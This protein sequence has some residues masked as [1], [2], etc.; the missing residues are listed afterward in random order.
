LWEKRS[1]SGWQ[2]SGRKPEAIR[3]EA[4]AELNEGKWGPSRI[5]LAALGGYYL[6][7]T[8]TLRAARF[9]GTEE[10]KDGR[11]AQTV[12][13][14]IVSSAHGIHTLYQ[15]VIDGRAMRDEVRKVDEGGTV[16]TP[17]DG[18]SAA[19]DNQWVRQEFGLEEL[20]EPSLTAK[21]EEAWRQ[22]RTVVSDLDARMT[23]LAGLRD[24][25]NPTPFVELEGLARGE[26]DE[27]RFVLNRTSETLLRYGVIGQTAS[28]GGGQQ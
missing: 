23:A 7:T 8:Q 12:L 25:D 17:S 28:N 4:L 13:E 19:M 2:V 6:A 11:D 5:E 16:E 3:D 15:A 24:G 14:R 18:T 10:V 26:V 27:V 22:I 20:P 9:F 1:Q 21:K